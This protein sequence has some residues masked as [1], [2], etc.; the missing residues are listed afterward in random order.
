MA[1]YLPIIVL[2][3]FCSSF[4]ICEKK[5]VV[6][7]TV[8]RI[9]IYPDCNDTSCYLKQRYQANH[10]VEYLYINSKLKYRR[11]IDKAGAWIVNEYLYNKAKGE[12][13]RNDTFVNGIPDNC[14]AINDSCSLNIEYFGDGGYHICTYGYNRALECIHAGTFASTI[15]FD[16]MYKSKMEGSLQII[17]DTNSVT[18]AFTNEEVVKIVHRERQTGIWRSYNFSNYKTDST[19]YSPLKKAE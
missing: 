15:V 17:C 14:F 4:N 7:G 11:I 16:S 10:I 12:E 3:L 8:N 6:N 1:K 5:V 9:Y 13:H 18:D 19:L 2:A